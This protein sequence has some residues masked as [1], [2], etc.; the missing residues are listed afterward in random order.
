[1]NLREISNNQIFYGQLS[2]DRVLAEWLPED[3]GAYIDIGAGYPVRGSNS[4]LFYKRGWRGIAIEPIKSNALIFKILRPRDTVINKLAGN[5]SGKVTFY[6]F[7]PYEYSTTNTEIA[8]LMERRADTK[9]IAKR[10]VSQMK[11]SDLNVKMSPYEATFISIDA[12][13]ADLDILKSISWSNCKPRVCCVEEWADRHNPSENVTD[14]L[15]AQGYKLVSNLSPSLIFVANE[16][17]MR[18]EIS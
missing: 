7:D 13:G 5:Q 16:Y 10:K 2:E 14:F 3:N 15:T 1:M 12:E 17:L 18:G 9:L 8:S 6:Q 4:Y 11:V